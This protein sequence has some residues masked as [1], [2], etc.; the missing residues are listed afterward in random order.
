VLKE[1]AGR[2]KSIFSLDYLNKVI[3]AK[4]L[5]DTLTLHLGDD[6]PLKI[7]FKVPD[8]LELSFILAPRIEE[9]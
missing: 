3:K 7:D 1:D 6:F 4:K 2:V 5:S 9:E 8:K